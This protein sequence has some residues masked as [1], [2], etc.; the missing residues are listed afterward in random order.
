LSGVS[1]KSRRSV[2]GGSSE[3]VHQTSHTAPPK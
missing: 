2:H 1:H 3:N